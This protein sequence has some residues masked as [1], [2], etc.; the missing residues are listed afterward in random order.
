MSYCFNSYF[1]R[2]MHKNALRPQI[3]QWPP[4]ARV[5]S[6]APSSFHSEFLA[7]PLLRMEYWQKISL[8]SRAPLVLKSL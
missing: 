5:R 2:N 4:S 3:P 7:T 8:M 6:Q 1:G